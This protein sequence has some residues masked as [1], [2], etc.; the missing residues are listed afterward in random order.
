MTAPSDKQKAI[1]TKYHKPIPTTIQEASQIISSLFGKKEEKT[2]TPK[3]DKFKEAHEIVE[4]YA[5]V[6]K[7]LGYPIEY[8]NL[9]TVWNTAIMQK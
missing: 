5:K 6:C 9:S 1:L 2:E 8:W 3:T 4:E 7:Q